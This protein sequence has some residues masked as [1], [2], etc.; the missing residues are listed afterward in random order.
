MQTI[1]AKTILQKNKSTEWFGNDYNINLYR[2]CCHGC[3]YCDSRSECYQIK[4]FDTVLSRRRKSMKPSKK[5]SLLYMLSFIIYPITIN[6]LLYYMSARTGSDV[7]GILFI[8]AFIYELTYIIYIRK[9]EN[10]GLGRSIS[11]FFLYLIYSITAMLF[12]G[13][14]NAFF[15]GY[16]STYFF[17]LCTGETCYGFSALYQMLFN[18]WEHLFDIPILIVFLIYTVTYYKISCRLKDKSDKNKL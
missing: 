16:T 10:I 17:G 6:E 2:G 11:R 14:I 7:I 18:S 5:F 4:S 15:N 12:V 1:S 3:I 8:L 9:R 13:Y